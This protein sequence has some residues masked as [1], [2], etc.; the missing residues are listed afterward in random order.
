MGNTT[1]VIS[2]STFTGTA[3]LN[4]VW[5]AEAMSNAGTIQKFKGN[6]E[7]D[8]ITNP[9]VY[10]S[11]VKSK[12]K[13]T[14]KEV[15]KSKLR[16]LASSV[17][18][19]KSTGQKAAFEEFSLAL[20]I[21]VKELEASAVG[22][23]KYVNKKSINLF[24]KVQVLADIVYFKP[25]EKYPRL[26]PKDIE[27]L[28]VELKEK[29]IFDEFWVL[30]L[31]YTGKELKTNKEKIKEKDPILFGCFSF[32]PDRLFYIADWVDDFCDLT[33]EKFVEELEANQ[34]ASTDFG[35][36]I[37]PVEELEEPDDSYLADILTEVNA[38]HNRLSNTTQSNFKQLMKEEDETNSTGKKVSLLNKLKGLF[39]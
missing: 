29:C 8:R 21:T 36:F 9:K 15:L 1:Y 14:E 16:R 13:E 18:R 31:D 4:E 17:K 38:R 28:L 33:L 20:A 35:R 25:I 6:K 26:M 2:N 24:K 34:E 30:Y 10:F 39:K 11:L 19:L 3:P 5:T 12:L 23:S 37:S 22:Y 32:A 7:G 27:A